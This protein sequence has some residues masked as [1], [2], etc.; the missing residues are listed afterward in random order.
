MNLKAFEEL[1]K[2]N[3]SIRLGSRYEVTIN[4]ITKNNDTILS[5]L[6]IRQGDLNISPTIYLNEYY[7]GY[8]KGQYTLYSICLLYTSPSPRDTKT[9]R[10]PSSA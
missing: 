1:V 6:T 10:M 4:K 7:E 9:Y 5:G 2:E 3:V 8:E